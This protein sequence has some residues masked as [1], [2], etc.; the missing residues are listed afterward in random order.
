MEKALNMFKKREIN[1]RESEE[2]G[3]ACYVYLDKD[4]DLCELVPEAYLESPILSKEDIENSVEQLLLDFA[5]FNIKYKNKLAK[6][7]RG[8]L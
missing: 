3:F 6:I 5:A 8:S 1:P 4:D 2:K 7:K